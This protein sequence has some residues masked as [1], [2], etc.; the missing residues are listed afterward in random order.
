MISQEKMIYFNIMG[1]DSYDVKSI[2]CSGVLIQSR[3]KPTK[4]AIQLFEQII[5][6]TCS[7]NK[8]YDY[9]C[10]NKEDKSYEENLK[11]FVEINEC[12]FYENCCEPLYWLIQEKNSSIYT[13]TLHLIGPYTIDWNA[14]NYLNIKC[15]EKTYIDDDL[16]DSIKYLKYNQI[17]SGTITILTCTETLVK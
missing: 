5:C 1:Y 10:K 7:D 14:K 15:Y 4:N 9:C 2:T 17:Y 12:K 3:E 11:S 13:N 6:L 8:F 16:V